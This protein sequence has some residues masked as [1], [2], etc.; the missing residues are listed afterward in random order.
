MSAIRGPQL[1]LGDRIQQVQRVTCRARWRNGPLAVV[2]VLPTLA[3]EFGEHAPVTPTVRDYRET[4][5]EACRELWRELTQTNRDLYDDPSIGGERDPGDYFDE[6]L[7]RAGAERV[8][9]A[10][11]DGCVVGFTAL[12]LDPRAPTGELEP[13]VVS[14]GARGIGV[15]RALTERVVATA[16]ELGLRRLDVRPVARNDPAIAFFHE[17]GFDTLGQLELMRYLTE[18][19]ESPPRV[20]IA[21]RDF[22]A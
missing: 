6:H 9:V 16:R 12:L 15:G 19:E 21:G 4:D 22:R 7:E 2:E 10:E 13:L 17:L 3:A 11:R 5:R 20:R 14:R 18:R 8:W 1:G